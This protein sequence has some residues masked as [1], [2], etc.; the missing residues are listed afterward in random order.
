MDKIKLRE[1]WRSFKQAF[2]QHLG[3][4]IGKRWA[5]K[6]FSLGL[7]P[8]LDDVAKEYQATASAWNRAAAHVDSADRGNIVAMN[9][10]QRVMGSVVKH[11]KAVTAHADKA[12]EKLKAYR[13]ILQQGLAGATGALLPAQEEAVRKAFGSLSVMSDLVKGIEQHAR[14]YYG[15]NA[16]TAQERYRSLMKQR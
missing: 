14:E 9:E 5:T 1:Q 16:R 3:P 13:D 4:V 10:V 12:Q 7:G 2:D 6:A 15:R 11:A 8:K